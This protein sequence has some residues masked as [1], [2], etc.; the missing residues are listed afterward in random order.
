MLISWISWVFATASVL[1]L[2]L[3]LLCHLPTPSKK[4]FQE[5]RLP[6]RT[7][8]PIPPS[9]CC[10]ATLVNSTSF[11]PAIALGHS[12]R[13]LNGEIPF[14]AFVD[15]RV[16]SSHRSALG[17]YFSV[18]NRSESLV[19]PEAAFWGLSACYPV[20]AVGAIGVFKGT[21]DAL[22]AAPPFSAVSRVGEV[23]WFD[24]TLMVLD[25]SQRP[26]FSAAKD[27]FSDFS[28]TEMTWKPLRPELSVEDVAHEYMEFWLRYL[29]PT[30][31]HFTMDTFDRAVRGKE[32]GE[33]SIGLFQMIRSIVKSAAEGHPELF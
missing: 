27:S 28:K 21:V 16:N 10:L 22:C 18:L 26:T 2:S 7:S 25:P 15:H 4:I 14:Y 8:P 33:G 17:E 9:T 3:E 19:F 6:A 32:V 12:L 31:I 1:S 20:V 13:Q 23:V 30:Y 5:R 29:S 11:R 24:P